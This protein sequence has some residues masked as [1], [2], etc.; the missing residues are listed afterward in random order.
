MVHNTASGVSIIIQTDSDTDTGEMTLDIFWHLRVLEFS[1]V[2][3][4]IRDAQGYKN[5]HSIS[6]GQQISEIW[7]INYIHVQPA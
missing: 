1:H 6:K 7:Q 5:L 2:I 4:A 3:K